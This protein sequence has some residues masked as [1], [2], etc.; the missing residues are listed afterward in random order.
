METQIG[1]ILYDSKSKNQP[2]YG[3]GIFTAD[4]RPNWAK[5]RN[6]LQKNSTNSKILDIINTAL[7]VICLDEAS[8]KV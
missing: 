7:I 2:D 6:E 8:P 1:R 5:I 4:E 3:I